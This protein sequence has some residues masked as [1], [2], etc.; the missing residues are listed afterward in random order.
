MP[1]SPGRVV[2]RDMDARQ[3]D[4]FVAQ[5]GIQADRPES[6]KT[7]TPTWT[8]FSA[9]PSGDLSYYDFGTI[10]MIFYDNSLSLVGTSN[11]TSMGIT[12][13]PASIQPRGVRRG[14]GVPLIDNGSAA[15]GGFVVNGATVTFYV[16]DTATLPGRVFLNSAGFTA[17]S[18]KGLMGGSLL[19]YTR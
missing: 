18:T 2:P 8:G 13:L 10:V 14:G 1:L 19:I 16:G 7:F 5:A 12:N 6:I 3:W 4:T 9:D 11:T 17:A 15:D